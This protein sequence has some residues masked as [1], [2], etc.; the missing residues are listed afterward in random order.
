MKEWFK[1]AWEESHGDV[2]SHPTTCI[3]RFRLWKWY[4][5]LEWL[6]LTLFERIVLYYLL[7]VLVA[8][9]LYWMMIFTII[10]QLLT[11]LR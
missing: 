11:V 3:G 7:L 5:W 2:M 9:I 6:Q 8:F 1:E 10:N 4:L